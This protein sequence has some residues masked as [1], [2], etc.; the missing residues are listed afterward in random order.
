MS[1]SMQLRI[2]LELYSTFGTRNI[3]SFY[4]SSE[5]ISFLS[6][7]IWVVSSVKDSENLKIFKSSIKS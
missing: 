3:K 4:Y 5:T 7:Q 1:L 2:L 6:P